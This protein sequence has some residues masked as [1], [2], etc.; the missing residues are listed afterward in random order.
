MQMSD[1]LTALMH[2][3]QVMNLLKTLI[4]KT[5][6]EREEANDG[7]YSPSSS[8]SSRQ[9]EEEEEYD[10]QHEMETSCESASDEEE[11]EEE[12]EQD[13]DGVESL[14]DIEECFLRQFG[15]NQNA[16]DG[17]C[18]QLEKIISRDQENCS[19]PFSASDSRIGSSFLSTSDGDESRISST[20]ASGVKMAASN[21]DLG[22]NAGESVMRKE[23]E[24]IDQPQF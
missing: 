23:M 3:V 4:T 10:S 19:S 5:L 1:P 15:E 7:G 9:S 13:R 6:R 22:E 17:F 12:E 16:K 11:E 2:A 24:V 21:L 20:T 8:L 14:S 18:K